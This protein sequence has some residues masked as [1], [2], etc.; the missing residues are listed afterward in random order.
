VTIH[1]PDGI[2]LARMATLKSALSLELKG[3]TRRGRSVYSIIKEE[4]NLK[5]NKQR[6]YDQYCEL[7][8]ELK[9]EYINE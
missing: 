1:T 8:E 7:Y 4:F 9:K 5:G 6:V 3:M 2:K